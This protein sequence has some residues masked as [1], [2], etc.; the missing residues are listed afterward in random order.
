[1]RVRV[2]DENIKH[3]MQQKLPIAFPPHYNHALT[4]CSCCGLLHRGA[5]FIIPCHQLLKC[6]GLLHCGA[7]H[8]CTMPDK[9]APVVVESVVNT[10]GVQPILISGGHLGSNRG[11]ILRDFQ[12]I[13]GKPC[14]RVCVDQLL[15]TFV[16]GDLRNNLAIANLQRSRAIESK[17][18]IVNMMRIINFA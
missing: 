8:A 11:G 10:N 2:G 13:A 1:M 6:R 16:G 9:R 4:Q 17:K 7:L 12:T 3:Y 15:S 18:A 5:P 14:L